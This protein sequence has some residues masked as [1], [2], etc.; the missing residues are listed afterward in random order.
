VIVDI[1]K[2]SLQILLFLAIMIC[3][4]TTGLVSGRILLQNV[5]APAATPN[6]TPIPIDIFGAFISS[7]VIAGGLFVLGFFIVRAF[8]KAK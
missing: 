8:H 2:M 4:L 1:S 5:Q 6:P 7:A 3:K